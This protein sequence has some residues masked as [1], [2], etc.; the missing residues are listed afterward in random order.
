ML[1]IFSTTSYYTCSLYLSLSRTQSFSLSHFR[2]LK[3]HIYLS[4]I[5]FSYK[6]P[7]I[8]SWWTFLPWN[9][10]KWNVLAFFLVTK[11]IF[12]CPHSRPW[13][14]SLSLTFYYTTIAL[15]TFLPAMK[16]PNFFFLYLNKNSHTYFNQLKCYSQHESIQACHQLKNFT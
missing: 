7:R 3:Y 1:T 11:C 15:S 10:F 16:T 2:H 5:Y 14:L 8:S 6:C 13:F 12:H 4:S 9:I